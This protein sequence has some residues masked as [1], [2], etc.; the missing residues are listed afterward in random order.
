MHVKI[1]KESLTRLENLIAQL[2]AVALAIR[3]VASE[4]TTS[5][6]AWS[7]LCWCAR[8]AETSAKNLTDVIIIHR[9]K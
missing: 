5:E 7:E 1:P 6:R 8:L 4:S 2:E 3:S 9:G